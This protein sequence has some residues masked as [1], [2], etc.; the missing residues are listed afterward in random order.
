MRTLI[1]P[2]AGRSSRFPGMK[3]K[4]LLTHPTGKPM[5]F[6]GLRDFPTKSFE[7][8]IITIHKSHVQDYEADVFLLQAAPFNFELCVLDDW[9]SGPAETVYQTINK[10][11]VVGEIVIKDSDNAASYEELVLLGKGRNFVVG[12]NIYDT[13][14]SKPE[15]KSFLVV[16]SQNLIV[17]IVEK[18][19]ISGQICAGIYGISSVVNFAESYNECLKVMRDAEI[20]ISHV[21]SHLVSS[22]EQPFE[23][24]E[25]SSF[26]DWGTL[27]DW[28]SVQ[29]RMSTYFS[30]FDGVLVRNAGKFGSQNWDS[31]FESLQENIAKLSELSSQGSQII[32]TTSRDI[33]YEK[34]IRNFLEENGVK[35]AAVICG[36]NHAPR[37]LI[38]DFAPTNPY[39]SAIAINIPRDANLS[40]YL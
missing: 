4:W 40:D 18:K 27:N 36:L 23:F 32:I 2:C 34:K 38:N 7:R 8:I 20:Y 29:K 11:K 17:D 5:V 26:E 14:V 19:I 25:A 9:T 31:E 13:Q 24:V 30:D 39:P 3:P 28:R 22:C 37:L 6:E 21:I 15:S 1:L 16:N 12:V 35:V 10:M 33:T